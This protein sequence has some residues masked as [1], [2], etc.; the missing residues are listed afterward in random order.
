MRSAIKGA[1]IGRRAELIALGVIVIAAV[2]LRAWGLDFGL[3]F[4]YH[5]DEPYLVEAARRM[6]QTGDLN[7]R[8]WDYPT[9]QIYAI[10]GLIALRE[11]FTDLIPWL[12]SPP[13]DYLL[14]RSLNLVYVAVTIVASAASARRL[15][16]PA[17]GITAALL[18][19]IAERHNLSSHFLKVDILTACFASLT[20]FAALRLAERPTWRA[21]LL[22]GIGVGLTTAGK[23][24]AATVAVSVIAAHVIATRGAWLTR[25]PRLIVAGGVAIASFVAAS[26]YTVL[27]FATFWSSFNND[28]VAWAA[29]GHAGW[30]GDVVAMYARW[31]FLDN[32]AILALL[33]TVGIAVA[34]VHRDRLPI[35]AIAF[36]VVFAIELTTLWTVRFPWYLLPIYPHLAVLAGYGLVGLWRVAGR[37]HVGARAA[38]GVA[39]VAGL[40]YQAAGS[41]DRSAALAS[42]D[43][44]TTALRWIEAN[45]PPG[46]HLVREGYTPLVPNGSIRVTDLWHAIDRPVSWYDEAEV[47]YV[48][49]GNFLHGRYLRDPERYP[50]Q[51]TAYRAL[52]R[53]AE[54]VR[55]FEGS[56][57]G[58]WGGQIDVYRIAR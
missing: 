18:I 56:M 20:L 24:P 58:S 38:I 33:A 49:L 8:F 17:A 30:E 37:A 1:S 48:V 4:P 54:R 23:Y 28:I 45:V 6:R 11:R 21:Y 46:S 34:A 51:A 42:E 39:V 3:P 7:P 14:G 31:L 57:L 36:P 52:I 19:A 53:R 27:D 5:L 22:A 32:D 55:R 16:G 29:G 13:L 41:I 9:L 2:A 43:V 15:A 35:V 44:R 50:V 25:A 40:A 12:A 47:D 10:L 26:P